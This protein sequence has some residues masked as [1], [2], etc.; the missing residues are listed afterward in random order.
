MRRRSP[1]L[2]LALSCGL[3]LAAGCSDDPESPPPPPPRP[4]VDQFMDPTECATCHPNHY[5]EWSASMHAY[6]FKDPVFFAMNDAEDAATGGALGQFC[7]TC[8]SPIGPITGATEGDFDPAALPSVLRH[9]VSC[10]V[11]HTM[12]PN[13]G[14]E[15]FARADE[16]GAR[17]LLEPGHN[18]FGPMDQVVDNTFHASVQDHLYD[19]SEVCLPCHNLELRGAPLEATFDEWVDSPFSAMGRECQDC[20]MPEYSGQAATGGP[21]RDNLHH[22]YFTGVDVAMTPFPDR[23][24]QKARVEALLQDAATLLV[25]TPPT[26]APGETILVQAN[27]FN[28]K[29][30]HSLPS[31]TTFE[32]QMWVEIAVT[33]DAGD[34]V[35]VSGSLDANGDLRDRHSE[36]DPDGDADL[37]LWTATIRDDAGDETVTVFRATSIQARLIGAGETDG[38]AYRVLVPA[39]ASGSL[40][41]SVRLLFRPFAPYLLRA[42]GVGP[43]QPENP[44]FEMATFA[45]DVPIVP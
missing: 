9:G 21:L 22:H 7:I 6:A 37:T 2:A 19:Q 15:S 8:H 28:D 25:G 13:S 1:S 5:A 45:G 43:L 40:H 42:R 38:G 3:L 32:R 17:L 39:A 27:V 44:I 23:A 11:C 26:A 35:Y 10:D 36:I 24:G 18:K 31:G 4:T 20:H 41:V 12:R 14:P 16:T 29:T 34:T 33:D 30:G